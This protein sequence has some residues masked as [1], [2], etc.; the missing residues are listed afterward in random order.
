MPTTSDDCI[1]CKIIAGELP[2]RI[3]REDERTVAFMDIAPATYGHTLVVPR[4]HAQDL[5]EIPAEDLEAVVRAG[6]A[7]AGRVKE[8]LGADGVNLINSCGSAAWQTVFHFHLHV[9]PR[10]A[11][12]PLKLPW[13]PAQ[14]DPD[15]IAMAAA[16]LLG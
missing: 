6:R 15:E 14:G 10:Y 8:R 9:I 2:A 13:I 11:D 7:V 12:D 4:N 3:V 5:L 1:F 16:Q